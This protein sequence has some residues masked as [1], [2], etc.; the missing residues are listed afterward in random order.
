[1]KTFIC[2]LLAALGEL[3]GCYAFWGWLRLGKNIVWTVPGTLALI[4]FAIA[5]TRIE[6]SQA[7]RVYA[8]YGGIYILSSVGWLWLIENV[9]PDRWDLLGVLI[10]LVGTLVILFSPHRT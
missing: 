6:A 7:G 5:L 8:A 2:F 4:M 9:K 3:A 1:M 10:S